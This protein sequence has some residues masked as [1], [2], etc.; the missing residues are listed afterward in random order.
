ML[1]GTLGRARSFVPCAPQQTVGLG[2][3]QL[4][5]VVLALS[6]TVSARAG[7]VW[8]VAST[9]GPS[10]SPRYDHTMVYDNTRQKVMLFGGR[11]TTSF[12]ND[13]W[14]WD[15]QNQ[16]APWTNVTP[17]GLKPSARYGHA[18]AYD[19]NRDKIVLFGGRDTSTKN[20]TW[21]WDP[22]TGNWSEITLAT[23]PSA[24]MYHGMAYDP[25]LGQMVLYGGTPSTGALGDTW[26]WD[27]DPTHPWVYKTTEICL[28]PPPPDAYGTCPRFDFGMTYN[29]AEGA[30]VMFG[31]TDGFNCSNS[32]P[33]YTSLSHTFKWDS[34]NSKW[35]RLPQQQ[36]GS[37]P[38][39]RHKHEMAWDNISGNIVLYGGD[40]IGCAPGGGVQQD[41]WTWN[42][43]AGW[44]QQ[45]AS[46]QMPRAG[47]AMAFDETIGATG[48]VV[49]HG[50]HDGS[51]L[52]GNTLV[53][54]A[55]PGGTTACPPQFNLS[56]PSTYKHRLFY[57]TGISNNI[58]WS[59]SISWG[60]NTIYEP[61]VPGV[62]AG[63][64][65]AALAAA[66]VASIN[67]HCQSDQLLAVQISGHPD[68]FRVIVGGNQNF[69]LCVGPAGQPPNCCV[70]SVISCSFNPVIS[71]ILLSGEDCNANGMDDYIDLLESPG[72]D[73]NGDGIIDT[74]QAAPSDLNCDGTV[75]GA[76]I[77]GFAL[78]LTNPAAY[79]DQYT[80]CLLI[81]ADLDGD[82]EVTTADIGPFVDGLI[83]A[84]PPAPTGACCLIDGTCVDDQS[85]PECS[86]A[87]GT[88]QGDDTT[89]DLVLCASD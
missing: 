26:E 40:T 47:H 16:S 14:E 77:A 10:P 54:Y 41:T 84:L 88:Y 11:N 73:G 55:V 5:A 52:F 32:A 36:V 76:D 22:A 39:R 37:P 24:R 21:E 70:S 86:A 65:A 59:W 30:I 57:I 20:D 23:S 38:S 53:G 58:P 48:G 83:G 68:Q 3:A 56:N 51:Q 78:A 1:R 44:A 18:M 69:S 25:G 27:G 2:L 87:G 50:G 35:W 17:P 80:D 7:Y 67:S 33:L 66:F 72:L 42:N 85:P 61:N 60:G 71:E 28:Q 12:F 79:Q 63:S 64:N 49:V 81:N 45:S 43:P 15:S 9:S 34:F 74:C 82:G 31:G 89:C 4:A 13:L 8:Q 19:S 46:S 75:S 29:G 62:P 6:C